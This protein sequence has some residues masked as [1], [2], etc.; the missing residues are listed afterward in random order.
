MVPDKFHFGGV[1]KRDYIPNWGI[2]CFS[3]N[4]F[5][6]NFT[7][8]SLLQISILN[9]IFAERRLWFTKLKTWSGFVIYQSVIYHLIFC[10]TSCIHWLFCRPGYFN[11]F[12]SCLNN[13]LR[14]DKL[15]VLYYFQDLQ[16]FACNF[17]VYENYLKNL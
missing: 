8:R 16:E 14:Y 4:L 17:S 11:L 5:L 7:S 1:N 12:N 13:V 6:P 15:A 10:E 9:R 3:I 2:R